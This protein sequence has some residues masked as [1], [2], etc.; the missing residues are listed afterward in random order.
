MQSISNPSVYAAGDCTRMGL[1]L[2]PV[3]NYQATVVAKNI[4]GE[5]AKVD[6]GVVPSTAFTIPPLATVGIRGDEAKPE[7]KVIFNDMSDWYSTKRTN[8]GYGASKVIIDPGT[9]RIMG[10]HFLGPNAEEV[11]NILAI[12][13]RFDIKASQIKE[14]M[15]AYPSIS[16]DIRYMI[17][18]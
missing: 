5:K 10:A 1:A 8:L 9:D 12:A 3:A 2:T 17:R 14:M 16:Y 11:I 7:H 13:M 4:K 18:D 6:L 15:L